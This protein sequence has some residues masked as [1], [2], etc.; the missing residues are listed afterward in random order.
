MNRSQRSLWAFLGAL[1]L[2]AGAP[3]FGEAAVPDQTASGSAAV[4]PAL[5]L[6]PEAQL[7]RELYLEGRLPNG[8]PLK[9]KRPGGITVTG[10]QAACVQCHRRSGLGGVEGNEAIPPITGRALF[11]GDPVLVRVDKRFN[12]SVS[13]QHRPYD[14]TSF[15]K[16]LRM[17]RDVSGRDMSTLMPRYDLTDAQVK[18]VSAYVR[19]LSSTWSPGV[20][21][22]DIHLATVIAPGVSPERRK[23]FLATLNAMVNQH[24][25]TVVSGLRQKLPPL[26]RRLHVRRNWTLDVWDLSGPPASW[27]AQLDQLQQQKPAFALLSGLALDEWQPVHDFCERSRVACWFPSVDLAPANVEQGRYGL[28]F[29]A[30]IDLEAAALSRRLQSVPEKPQRVVQVFAPE[31]RARHA[32]STL[33]RLL[34]K[35]GIPVQDMEWNPSVREDL[36][37]VLGGLTDHDSVVLW[38]PDQILEEVGGMAA[39]PGAVYVSATLAESG[40]GRLPK[41]WKKFA[42]SVQR[43][44]LAK[45][46]EANLFRFNQWRVYRHLPLVD[47]KM[48]AEVFFA[49]NALSWML[50]A[51]LNN[52]HT[53]YLIERAE[54]ELSMREAMQVQEEVQAMMMGGGGSRPPGSQTGSAVGQSMSVPEGTPSG[55]HGV[56]VQALMKRQGTSPYPRLGLGPGQRFASKG[57]YLIPLKQA[58]DG[59]MQGTEAEWL[60]P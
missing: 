51:M 43:L 26:E 50:T 39:P 28:Y 54:A 31:T 44:E 32:A 25:V 36:S 22:T 20:T 3:G 13:V 21:Q 47:E 59:S 49:G 15:A 12:Q 2:V 11:G 37:K 55:G 14:E 18:S 52:L 9:G 23:A 8:S 35:A 7:G 10:K 58:E 4:Q 30:G 6:S 48:Q 46:R 56:D 5:P 38:L 33:H 17:G 45:M 29:S 42:W 19:T 24:N 16:A 34:D 60:V 53:D 1:A 40:I 57:A 27:A 41:A